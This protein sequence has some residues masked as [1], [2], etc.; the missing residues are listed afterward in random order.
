MVGIRR[1]ACKGR[2]LITPQHRSTNYGGLVLDGIQMRSGEGR[3]A[4]GPPPVGFT[5][6]GWIVNDLP[7]AVADTPIVTCF[8]RTKI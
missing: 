1:P 2:A 6:F 4:F 8:S 5:S 3:E 7:A